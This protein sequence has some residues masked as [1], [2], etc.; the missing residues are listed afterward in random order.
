MRILFRAS[1]NKNGFTFSGDARRKFFWAGVGVLFSIEERRDNPA[2]RDFSRQVMQ[3]WAYYE[4]S[5]KGAS[6]QP[7]RQGLQSV[8]SAEVGL[9]FLVKEGVT[10]SG[11]RVWR[12]DGVKDSETQS[13]G[14]KEGGTELK[15]S[16]PNAEVREFQKHDVINRHSMLD[17]E[18]EVEVEIQSNLRNLAKPLQL[19]FK[20]LWRQ[21]QRQVEHVKVCQECP[22][23]KL[24][25][26]SCHHLSAQLCF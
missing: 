1:C 26:K 11:T 10:Q 15:S 12:A 9:F 13:D 19:L 23:W 3:R 6:G 22:R 8:R 18:S 21:A 25:T 24:S 16:N 4:S 7:R 14:G 2:V 17:A 20:S 5:Y